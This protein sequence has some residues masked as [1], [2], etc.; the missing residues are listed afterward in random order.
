MSKERL[1]ELDEQN[2]KLKEELRRNRTD[3]L[4]EFKKEHPSFWY[5]FNHDT[6]GKRSPILTIWI[7]MVIILAV[8]LLY[9]NGDIFAPESGTARSVLNAGQEYECHYCDWKGNT[10]EMM[11]YSGSSGIIYYCPVCGEPIGYIPWGDRQG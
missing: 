10:S 11:G 1:I 9:A 6:S 2:T 4:I 3:L 5:R 7:I 8:V